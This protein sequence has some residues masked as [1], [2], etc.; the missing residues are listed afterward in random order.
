[1]KFIVV[2]LVA[3][4]CA[5]SALAQTAD[6]EHSNPKEHANF[7]SSK[8]KICIEKNKWYRQHELVHCKITYNQCIQE[9]KS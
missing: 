4:G 5:E 2:F 9:S 1:M 8:L 6:T 7:C 3:L